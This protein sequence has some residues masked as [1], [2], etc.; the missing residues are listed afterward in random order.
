M[1]RS[2]LLIIDFV[3]DYLKAGLPLKDALIDAGAVRLRPI[4]LTTL[5]ITFGKRDFDSRPRIRRFGHHFHIWNDR[6]RRFLQFFNSN[7]AERLFHEASI[8]HL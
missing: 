5:A 7:S 8:P 1:V 6:Y 2:S 3:L 4:L